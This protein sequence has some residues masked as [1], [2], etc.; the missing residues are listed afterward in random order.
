MGMKTVLYRHRYLW[1][2]ADIAEVVLSFK[3]RGICSFLSNS[4]TIQLL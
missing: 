2:F 3:A 1:L 4:S